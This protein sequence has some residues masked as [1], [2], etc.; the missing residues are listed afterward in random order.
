MYGSFPES[1]LVVNMSFSLKEKLP[2]VLLHNTFSIGMLL[3]VD[4]IQIEPDRYLDLLFTLMDV[5]RA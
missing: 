4:Q 5:I 3:G 1:M 2:L